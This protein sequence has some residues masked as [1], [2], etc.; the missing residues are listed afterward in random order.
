MK[1][2]H[3]GRVYRRDQP[4]VTRGRFREFYQCDFDIAG[5]AASPPM[6]PD[7]ECLKVLTEI[8]D[9]LPIGE[10]TIKLNHRK[11]LDAVMEVAGVPHDKF[12]SVCSAIDKLDKEPW[13][14]VEAEIID[15]LDSKHRKEQRAPEYAAVATAQQIG[16]IIVGHAGEP[17]ALLE[18]LKK[19]TALA[20]HPDASQAFKELEAMCG[21]MKVQ[22]LTSSGHL[23][24]F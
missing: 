6:L 17:F 22:P 19:N 4:V 13:S 23:I 5:F 9:A 10:Y 3:I 14:L 21:F 2:F 11:I 1:R 24:F 12:R 18:E 8:L 16:K 20:T 7:A 15:K